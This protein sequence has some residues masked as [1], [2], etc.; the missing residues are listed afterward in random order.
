[1]PNGNVLIIAWEIRTREEAI[2]AGRNP[3]RIQ[4]K[5]LW[6][7]HIIEVESTGSSSGDIVWE[8]HVWDH[9]IQDYDSTKDNYGVVEDHPELIDFNFGNIIPDWNHINSVDYHEEFDQIL[10]SVNYFN[11]IWVIDHSTTTEEA[12]GHTGGKSGKGGDLLYRWGNPQVYR[13][14]TAN[15]QKYFTQHYANWIEKGCPGEGNI[16]VFNNG[17]GRAYS[18]VD[19]IVPPVDNQGNYLYT[20]GEAYGPK[21]QIWIYTA[22]NLKDLYSFI[23]SNAQRLPNG[24]TLI[25][26]QGRGL[27]LEVTYEKDIVWRYQNLL[28]NPFSNGVARVQRYPKDYPGIPEVK[29]RSID[30]I[31]NGFNDLVNLFKNILQRFSFFQSL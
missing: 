13:A 6:P 15:D 18:S 2:A 12:A 31:G 26:N 5:T 30:F 20:S 14:G 7:D 23:L 21:E 9:L 16:I 19:E 28:P 1:L 17:I 25:C 24:N 11:E 22:A 4:G 10:L 29:S 27:F 8:W 3:N